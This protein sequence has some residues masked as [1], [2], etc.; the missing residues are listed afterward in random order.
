MSA[1]NLDGMR[2]DLLLGGIA[3]K[4][5]TRL[6]AELTDHIDDLKTQA[7]AEGKSELEA[8]AYA[9]E[10]IGRE[11]EIVSGFLE[12]TELKSYSW[13]Y[14][15]AVFLAG[16]MLLLLGSVGL[17]FLS[18]FGITVLYPEFFELKTNANIAPST[19]AALQSILFFNCYL[20]TPLLAASFCVLAK[21]RSVPMLLPMIGVCIVAA[22]GSGFAY[23]LTWPS[24]IVEGSLSIN[25]GY[26]F[27]PRYIRGNHDVQNYM[28]ILAVLLIC[29]VISQKY[30]PN[31]A[32]A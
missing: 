8:N 9:H 6:L 25:W 30:K 7:I 3:P 14:P 10:A 1:L 29:I 15:K 27:L 23:T 17:F 12:R 11:T 18:L 20:L 19:K 28:Q 31:A 4:T 2:R 32:N 26:S 22:F 5:V 21:K 24:E 16:P 13:R